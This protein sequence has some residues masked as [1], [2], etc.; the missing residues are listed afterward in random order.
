MLKDICIEAA[1]INFVCGCKNCNSA[2]IFAEYVSEGKWD[3]KKVIAS[4]AIDP[5]GEWVLKG[6]LEKD[7]YSNLK[8]I[9]EKTKDLPKFRT[10]GVHG[11]FFA[12]SGSSIV[13]EVAFSLAQG[14]EYLSELTELGLSIDNVAKIIK[15]ILLSVR[16]NINTTH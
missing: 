5:L 7:A 4:T 6:K 13:Q 14:A 15:F 16:F 11:K 9:I 12:N 2:E 10:L 3:N 1:E 8:S